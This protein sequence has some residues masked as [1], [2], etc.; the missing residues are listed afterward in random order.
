MILDPCPDLDLLRPVTLDVQKE[1][2]R[3][4]GWFVCLFFS[5]ISMNCGG[6]YMLRCVSFLTA[7]RSSQ[8]WVLFVLFYLP[9]IKK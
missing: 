4:H 3:F 5:D 8:Q 1:F 9:I 7:S 2:L 6:Y